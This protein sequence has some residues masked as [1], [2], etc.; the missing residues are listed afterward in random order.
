MAVSYELAH[1]TRRGKERVHPYTSEAELGPGDVVRLEGRDWL[2]ERVDARDDG[3][4]RLVTKPARY[5]LRL[6]HPD[7]HEELGAFRRFRPD[8]PRVGHTFSTLEDGQPVSWQVADER[9]AFDEQEEPYLDLTAERD[10]S[11]REDQPDLPEHELEHALARTEGPEAAAVTLAR[12]EEAGLF[13]EL[14]ALEPGEA[15]DWGEAER[16]IDALILEEIEDDLLVTCGVNPNSDPRDTWID[17]VKE[18]LRTDLEQFRGDIEGDHDAIEEWDFQDGS[19]FAAVG[20]FEDEANPDSGHG[21][22]TRLLDA[23]ALAAAGFA[24]VRKAELQV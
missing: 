3:P 24:R 20:S 14:V 21:W 11:E 16:Y 15:P 1:V 8:A 19:V 10:Y 5:R 22:M 13:I 6:R 9:L 4:A 17:T 23:S 2:V 12:A 7:G 18:R